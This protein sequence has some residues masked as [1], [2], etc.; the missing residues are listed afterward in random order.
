MTVNFDHFCPVTSQPGRRLA[1][2][3]AASN[4]STLA[5][6]QCLGAV[7]LLADPRE[8]QSFRQAS[9]YLSAAESRGPVIQPKPLRL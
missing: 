7:L 3:T 9:C 5:A 6:L 4:D 8:S 2:G 1:P